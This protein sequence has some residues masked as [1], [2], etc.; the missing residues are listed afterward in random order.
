MFVTRASLLS[1]FVLSA[2]PQSAMADTPLGYLEG[3][4]SKALAIVPLTW[5]LLI[6]SMAVVLIVSALVMWGILRRHPGAGTNVVARHQD[7]LRYVYAGIALTILVLAISV[8]WTMVVLA[9]INSPPGTPALTLDVTAKQWWWDVRYE[10]EKPHEVFETANE[11]HIPVG[12]PVEIKLRSPDVI[13]SFWIP[14]LTGKTDVIPGQTNTTWMQASNAGTF[15]GQCAE[16]CGLEHARMGLRV[17]AEPDDKFEAW[18]A[19]QLEPP[20]GDPAGG[21]VFLQRCG[22]C[23]AV[24]GTAAGGAYGPDLSHLMTRSTLAAG[25]IPNTPG[26]LSAWIIDPERIKPG[27]R[28]PA[29]GL[30][31]PE[32]EK[33]RTY[34]A[35]LQ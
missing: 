4:G 20:H 9:K 6:L 26:Y 1:V 29:V 21:I 11:I 5:G 15:I 13:H 19:K 24:R 28:M 8:G 35:T 10:S 7:G 17:I 27:T 14:A 33:I 12:K 34:L 18:R 31:G 2:C 30:S 23:H 16:F 22:V 3:H 32:L 25:T